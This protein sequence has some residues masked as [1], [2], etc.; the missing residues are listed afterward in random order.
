MLATNDTSLLNMLQEHP[1]SSS[2]HPVSTPLHGHSSSRESLPEGSPTPS[3]PAAA[4]SRRSKR[5]ITIDAE[6]IPS[7][8]KR[9][10]GHGRSQRTTTA[11]SLDH[12]AEGLQDI[13]R[14]FALD[15]SPGPSPLPQPPSLDGDNPP[16]HVLDVMSTPSRRRVAIR[17]IERDGGLA[18]FDFV[19]AVRLIQGDI[20]IADVY[21]AMQEPRNRQEFI[22]SLLNDR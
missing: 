10:R 5:S 22:A 4:H 11:S 16:A 15:A 1:I 19:K 20:A 6:D 3:T 21:L 9:S 17:S 18:P 13:A 14:A 7:P 12:I 2:P 8:V